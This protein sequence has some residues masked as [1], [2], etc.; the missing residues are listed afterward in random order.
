MGEDYLEDC[1][2]YIDGKEFTGISTVEIEDGT[3]DL[4]QWIYTV[5]P[6]NRIKHLMLNGKTLRVKIKNYKR[7]FYVV[8]KVLRKNAI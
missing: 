3:I 1:K 5:C 6:N 2:V 4:W 7:A 8:L